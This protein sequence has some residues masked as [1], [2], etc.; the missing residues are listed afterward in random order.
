MINQCWLPIVI[1][2]ESIS[3]N[4]LVHITLKYSQYGENASALLKFSST[5]RRLDVL[6]TRKYLHTKA[7]Q[8]NNIRLTCSAH[9]SS[10]NSSLFVLLLTSHCCHTIFNQ[11]QHSMTM[12]NITTMK[13][14]RLLV[15]LIVLDRNHGLHSRIPAGL[16]SQ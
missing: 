9:V 11:K 8:Q 1:T 4:S 6:G 10:C 5:F 12:T 2:R 7:K 13:W 15:L 3:F 16:R 14:S